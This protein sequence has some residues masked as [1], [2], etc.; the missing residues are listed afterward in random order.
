MEAEGCKLR[1]VENE[2]TAH[3]VILFDIFVPKIIKSGGNLAKFRL[4]TKTMLHIM[5]FF[6]GD[7]V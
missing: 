1:Q 7:T 5:F 3:N 6:G 4:P 2:C